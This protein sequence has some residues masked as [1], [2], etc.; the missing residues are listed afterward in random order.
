[1]QKKSLI[2]DGCIPKAVSI[3][4][5]PGL[6]C[7]AVD[8]L[9]AFAKNWMPLLFNAFLGAEPGRRGGLARTI[10]AYARVCDAA[11]LT[12]LFHTVLKKLLKVR[13][14]SVSALI[15][16]LGSPRLSCS[17]VTLKAVAVLLFCMRM[18]PGL[19][20][21]SSRGR[22]VHLRR[23]AHVRSGRLYSDGVLLHGC[24][25]SRSAL[26]SVGVLISW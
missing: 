23:A 22:C 5:L 18:K 7:R 10:D 2:L 17:M 21:A 14:P 24:C 1:V 6:C 4:R 26:P 25:S 12:G 20:A 8:A 3:V 16:L 13:A 9:R 15:V 19:K 11:F